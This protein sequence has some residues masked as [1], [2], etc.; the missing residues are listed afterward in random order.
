MVRWVMNGLRT[1]MEMPFTIRIRLLS[2][3]VMS[4]SIKMER[5]FLSYQRRSGLMPL[6]I[7]PGKQ[8]VR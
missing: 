5:L 1:K 7:S 3:S 6:K 2:T 8:Q 4:C